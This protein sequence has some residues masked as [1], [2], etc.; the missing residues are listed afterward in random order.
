MY[1]RDTMKWLRVFFSFWYK[2]YFGLMFFITFLPQYPIYRF[3]TAKYNR[4]K[5]AFR[6][7]KAWA[8]VYRISC[9]IFI[10]KEQREALPNTPYIICSNHSSFLDITLMYSIIPDFFVFMGKAE[11]LNWPLINVF[12]K[13]GNMDIAVNRGRKM[14]AA[15]SLE[16]AAKAL[17]NGRCVVIFPEGGID[18]HSPKLSRFKNGAFRLAIDQQVPIV[19]VTFLTN[20]KLMSDPFD[21]KV[22]T[23]PGVS[24]VIVH[25]PVYTKGLN[26]KDLVTLRQQVFDTINTEL[27]LNGIGKE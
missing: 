9:L 7:K 1:L 23:R 2:L 18:E 21:K 15:R 4:V 6:L 27:E 17:E 22:L 19:P 26:D 8:T 16:L 24:K 20:H 13:N 12:F 5:Y 25:P 10:K 11:L 14:E 3:L